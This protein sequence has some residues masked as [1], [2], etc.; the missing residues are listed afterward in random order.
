MPWSYGA[1]SMLVECGL[2]DVVGCEISE[3]MVP[4]ININNGINELTRGYQEL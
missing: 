4:I 2:V 1:E 3:C